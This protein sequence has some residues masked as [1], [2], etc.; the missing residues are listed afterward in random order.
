MLHVVCD[1]QKEVERIARGNKN[2]RQASSNDARD[3]GAVKSARTEPSRRECETASN[4]SEVGDLAPPH[5]PTLA[6]AATSRVRVAVFKTYDAVPNSA[7]ALTCRRRHVHERARAYLLGDRDIVF[8]WQCHE[9]KMEELIEA[10]RSEKCIYV[11]KHQDYLNTKLKDSIWKQIAEAL[12]LKDGSE[13]KKCWE[14]L[15][16]NHRDAL[17]RQ[18]ISKPKSGSGAVNIKPWRFQKKYGI[19]NPAYGK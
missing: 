3:V 13:A 11:V 8:E 18:K 9:C 1:E 5:M 10:V 12:N 4:N 19:L 14:K 6:L 7:F 17:R 16:N 2:S 15:R